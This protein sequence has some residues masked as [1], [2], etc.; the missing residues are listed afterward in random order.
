MNHETVWKAYNQTIQKLNKAKGVKGGGSDLLVK[1]SDNNSE[2][3][4]LEKNSGAKILIAT[5]PHKNIFFWSP[6]ETDALYD[7]VDTGFNETKPEFIGSDL[8]ALQRSEIL[9]Q[10]LMQYFVNLNLNEKYEPKS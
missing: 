2:L 9:A 7:F 8:T 5:N 6:A 1:V 4:I 10:K 3:F